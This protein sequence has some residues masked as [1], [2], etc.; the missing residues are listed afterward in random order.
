MPP[1]A[2]LPQHVAELGLGALGALMII[3][4]VAAMRYRRRGG[5]RPPSR[6]EAEFPVLLGVG[7]I[8]F[9]LTSEG[10]SASHPDHYG[11]GGIGGFVFAIVWVI[12]M[13]VFAWLG[14]RSR[15]GASGPANR[16][17]GDKWVRLRGKRRGGPGRGGW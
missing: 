9:G 14:W 17:S 2:Y 7:L 5:D 16:S 11:W 13:A 15:F 10:E 3:A 6:W 12:L 8:V 1:L 4:G